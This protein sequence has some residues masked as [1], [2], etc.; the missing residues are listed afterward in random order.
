MHLCRMEEKRVVFMGTP[1]FAVASLRKML[2]E[3]IHVVG[4]V[5]VPDKPAGRGQKMHESAVK[6]FAVAHHIPVLQPE[7]LKSEVFLSQLA[8]WNASLFVVVAFRMLPKEVWLMPKLGTINLHG[9]LLP[10]Y[11]GAAPI[12]W[13][14]IHGETTTGVTTFFIDQEIDTGKVIDQ[15]EISIGENETTGELHDK[16][17]LIG[18]S[19]LCHTIQRIFSGKVE[20]T[21]QEHLISSHSFIHHAPKLTKEIAKIDWDNRGKVIHDFIRGLSPYP[22]AWFELQGKQMRVYRGHVEIVEHAIQVGNWESDMK[23]HLKV[24]V[25]DGWYY[26]DEV[27]FEG[28]KRMFILDFLRGWKP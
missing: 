19:T 17:M 10:H 23:T 28:K 3:N 8:S 13:A 18:A 15:T 7:K 5:T 2:Q 11:R 27:Q 1:E 24:A 6:Q 22:C 20:A 25:K 12:H 4:V 26:L 9:S 14:V 21:N 16:M